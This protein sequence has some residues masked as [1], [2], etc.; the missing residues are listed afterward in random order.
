MSLIISSISINIILIF[1]LSKIGSILNLIQDSNHK[2][3]I[4]GYSIFLSVNYYFYFLFNLN[5]EKII[6]FWVLISSYIFFDYFLKFYKFKKFPSFLGIFFLFSVVL[7]SIIYLLPVILYGEQFYIF[8]GN[9][10]DFFSYLSIASLFSN[11]DFFSL[12]DLTT[13]PKEYLHFDNIEKLIFSRPLTSLIIGIFI[14]LINTDIFLIMYLFKISLLILIVISF[15]QFISNFKYNNLDKIIITFVF[16]FTF[17]LIY[18]FEIEAYSHLA[19]IPIFLIILSELDNIKKFE[20]YDFKF[21]LYFGT[22]NSS[23]FLVYPELFCISSIIIIFF[24]LN[25][26]IYLKK[27]VVFLNF[28]FL[29]SLIFLILTIPSL[30]TNY[31]FLLTQINMSV[32]QNNDWWGY[33]GAFILGNENLVLNNIFIENIKTFFKSNDLFKTVKYIISLH[34]DNGYDY[35]YLNIIPSLYGLYFISIGKINTSQ[36]WLHLIFL[37]CFVVY[38][39]NLSIKNFLVLLR[40][41]KIFFI[42]TFFLLFSI[43]ISLK[44]NFWAVIKLYTYLSP[45]IYIF[46]A[47]NFYKY[48]ETKKLNLNYLV[49]FLLILFP[50]YKYTSYNHGISKLDSFPS[51]M[52]PK[53]KTEFNWTLDYE[54]LEKCEYVN[55][56]VDDYFQKSF[57]ILKFISN[58]VNSNILNSQH[59]VDT[60]RCYITNKNNIFDIKI[61]DNKN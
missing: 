58:S 47:T 27:R 21:I 50:L 61:I 34:F 45:L 38:L 5:I 14:K 44:G 9:H 31:I 60:N 28:T 23:L 53:M 54:K 33:F 3:I 17:W 6:L 30:K 49:V 37:S 7:I 57:L 32:N 13:F 19:S 43:I 26:F 51:I 1:L 52:H 15:R 35:F 22:L 2:K 55:V 59:I 29:F 11:Y 41:K 8:R 46:V 16:P 24:L 39:I 56:E 4:F 10:W 40:A 20:K 48:K 12:N 18:V 36:D 25:N 42:S